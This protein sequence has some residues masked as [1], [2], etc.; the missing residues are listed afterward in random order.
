M[1][2]SSFQR[3]KLRNH[4]FHESSK[5]VE[6][7]DSFRLLMRADHDRIDATENRP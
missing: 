5:A 6:R 2:K 1:G 4:N 7:G 3:V